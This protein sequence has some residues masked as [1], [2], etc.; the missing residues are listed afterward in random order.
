MKTKEEKEQI[1]TKLG[2]LLGE[3]S[4][5]AV[6]FYKGLTMKNL[7]ELRNRIRPHGAR[8]MVVK[9]TL[10]QIA[11][12]GTPY[13]DIVANLEG[14]NALILL[15][16]DASAALKTMFTF[17]RDHDSFKLL[18][19]KIDKNALDTVGLKVYSELPTK[20]EVRAMFV[21]VLQT[22][23]SMLVGVLAGPGRSFVGVISAYEDKLGGRQAA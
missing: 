11:A 20:E 9:N 13:E 8:F 7:A 2:K 12:K 5:I 14:P 4:G 10:A 21:G 6:C 22:S 15:K 19:G 23:T 18:K 1:I 16:D 17:S 3:C